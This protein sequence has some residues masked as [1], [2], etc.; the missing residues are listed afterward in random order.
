MTLLKKITYAGGGLALGYL[1]S[2]AFAGRTDLRHNRGSAIGRTFVIV[3][4]GFAGVAVAAQLARLLPDPANGDIVLI[5]EDDFLLF[6][7]MLTEVVGDEVDARHIIH[8][9]KH[10]SER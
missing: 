10:V 5:D 7:P 6:T 2:K 3:G 9:V 8:P 4:A 1:A